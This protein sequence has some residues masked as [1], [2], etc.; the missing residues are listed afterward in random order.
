MGTRVTQFRYYKDGHKNNYPQ[1]KWS[2]YCAADNF[3]K[4]SPIMAIGIQTLPGTKIY[5]NGSTNPI[6]IGSNGI[7]ELDVRNTSASIS[8]IRVDQNSMNLIQKLQNG[9]FIMDMVY[10]EQKEI[11]V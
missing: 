5:L 7:F 2:S 8:S 9:Y 11:E 3:R 10:E 6:I 1:W 4:Y